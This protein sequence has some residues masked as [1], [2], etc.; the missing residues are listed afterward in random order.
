MKN[1]AIIALAALALLTE[2]WHA[3]AQTDS[4]DWAIH[5]VVSV[6]DNV[7]DEDLWFMSDAARVYTWDSEAEC[8][9]FLESNAD[10]ENTLDTT[11]QEVMH[12]FGAEAKLVVSC[13]PS[14]F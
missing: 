11:R 8:K 9:A 13:A 7:V 14:P 10:L 4:G 3:R 5:G 2:G 12:E 6:G 1:I